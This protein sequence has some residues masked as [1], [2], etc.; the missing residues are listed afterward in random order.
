VVSEVEAAISEAPRNSIDWVTFVGSGETLLHASL[1]A[2]IRG[3]KSLTGLPLAVITNGSLLGHP[4]VRDELLLADAILPSLDA[5]TTEL[6]RRINRPH[7]SLSFKQHV[8][9]LQAFRKVYRG[10]LFLELMLLKDLNDSEEALES[11]ASC[12]RT[13]EPD[14][15]HLSLPDRPPAEPWVGPPPVGRVLRAMEI[16]GGSAKVL[17]PLDG[18][19][20][21]SSKERALENILSVIAR[22]PLSD[23]Q[24]L[25]A[26]SDWT[27][28]DRSLLLAELEECGRATR[29][30]R[31]GTDFWVSASTRFP[32]AE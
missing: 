25:E 5:G 9:G 20:H 15:L 23:R 13:I 7:P 19:I 1:G 12:V 26:L 29:I 14:E 28:T 18:I 6:F 8:S 27:E 10:K 21:L 30:R 11:I 24:L 31:K 3:V 4:D 17:E 16:L 2:L 32:K 22:H